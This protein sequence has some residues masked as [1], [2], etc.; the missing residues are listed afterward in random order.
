MFSYKEKAVRCSPAGSAPSETR[1]STFVTFHRHVCLTLLLMKAE[2]QQVLKVLTA[3]RHIKFI[4]KYRNL[5]C[6]KKMK[7]TCDCEARECAR[8]KQRLNL[9][10]AARSS[11]YSP[12]TNVVDSDEQKT[13]GDVSSA[14]NRKET[15]RRF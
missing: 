6:L 13:S 8:R 14:A 10:K 11:S 5:S 9:P 3:R 4:Q 15:T 2:A 1:D 12:T 7:L